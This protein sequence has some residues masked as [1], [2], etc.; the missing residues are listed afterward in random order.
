M[1]LIQCP[2][3][4]KMISDRVNNCPFC[5]C[6][7]EYFIVE[8]KKY[9]E[10]YLEVAAETKESQV[11]NNVAQSENDDDEKNIITLHKNNGNINFAFA[12]MGFTYQ[13]KEREGASL[14]GTYLKM[15]DGAV[16]TLRRRYSCATNISIAL[17]KVQAEASQLVF[18]AVKTAVG[19]LYQ[20]GIY[21]TENQFWEKYYYDYKMDYKPYFDKILQEY[22]KIRN[23]ESQMKI[24][25]EAEKASRGKWQGGGFGFGGAIKGAM[26]AGALNM[27][28]NAIYSF[29]DAANKKGDNAQ[30]R[31]RLDSLYKDGE[32]S[33]ILCDSIKSCIMN[34]YQALQKEL[35]ISGVVSKIVEL[36]Q[37]KA[38]ALYEKI[39]E[40]ESDEDIIRQKLAECIKYYPGEKKFYD[41]L[42]PYMLRYDKCDFGEFLEYWNIEYLYPDFKKEFSEGHNFDIFFCNEMDKKE[43]SFTSIKVDQYLLLRSILNEYFGQLGKKPDFKYSF[44]TPKI[45][46]YLKLFNEIN[47]NALGCYAIFNWI[48]E[49]YS[50]IEF[51]ECIKSERAFLYA[52]NLDRYWLYGDSELQERVISPSIKKEIIGSKDLLLFYDTSFL[53]NGTKGIALTEEYIID[54]KEKRKIRLQEVKEICVFDDNRVGIYDGKKYFIFQEKYFSENAHFYLSLLLQTFCARYGKNSYVWNEKMNIPKPI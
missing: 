8:E 38:I 36:N 25:R 13:N 49:N 43:F 40:Y 20:S 12:G 21:M 1:P 11:I 23:L 28:A 44:I 14:F 45:E 35:K 3:C 31:S 4:A 52:A 50:A 33:S 7:A 37:E 19:C 9:I 53:G 29:G 24:Y 22:S 16:A 46:E 34:V 54:V 51:I 26:M 41:M 39:T 6:P 48:P 2:D 27:G 15:A 32:T 42:I 17:E 10:E 30:V 47:D 5:G 18:E